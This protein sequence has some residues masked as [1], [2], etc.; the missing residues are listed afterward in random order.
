MKLFAAVVAASLVAWIPAREAQDRPMRVLFVGN[1][2]TYFNNLPCLV[3]ELGKSRGR[4]IEA[5]MIAEGGATLGRHWENDATRAEVR[6]D[7]DAIVLQTQSAFGVTYFVDGVNRISDTSSL[8]RDA[9]NFTSAIGKR[10]TRAV[11]YEQWKAQAA[12]ARDQ[13][14]IHVAFADAARALGASVMPAGDAWELAERQV[15]AKTLYAVDGSH[16]SQIGSYLTAL[17]AYATLTGDDPHGL[18]STVTCPAVDLQTERVSTTT[19]TVRI[20]P[21]VL[22]KLQ[23]AAAEAIRA[24]GKTPLPALPAIAAPAMPSGE[25]V[26]AADLEGTWSGTTSLY[27]RSFTW[28][29]SITLAF[30]NHGSARL[31]LSFGGRPDDI[32]RDVS[33][34][35]AD[36]VLQFSDPQGPNQTVVKYRAVRNGEELTGLAEFTGNPALYGIGSWSVRRK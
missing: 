29:A 30:V 17:T 6:K 5:T 35:I 27:P 10:K 25:K 32:V 8:L 3:S 19:T 33:V 11:L 36:G 34:R 13:L 26:R 28:P 23:D 9:R 31:T 12:P 16:P 22:T 1:S 18:P 20:D 4:P 2:Y 24:W 21:A 14:A 7:W 15:E